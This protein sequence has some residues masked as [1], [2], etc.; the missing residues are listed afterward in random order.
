MYFC[1]S[2][3]FD[4][5]RGSGEVPFNPTYKKLLPP[6]TFDELLAL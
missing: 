6:V 5:L 4:A 3:G 2:E 1:V